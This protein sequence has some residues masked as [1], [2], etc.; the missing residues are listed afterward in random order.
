MFL[1]TVLDDDF[2]EGILDMRGYLK[3][4]RKEFRHKGHFGKPLKFARVYDKKDPRFHLTTEELGWF[5]PSAKNLPN[6]TYEGDFLGQGN[7]ADIKFLDDLLPTEY[8][9]RSYFDEDELPY[10]LNIDSPLQYPPIHF[11]CKLLFSTHYLIFVSRSELSSAKI[12]SWW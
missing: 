4:K 11:I 2:R 7:E 1:S 3:R 6:W 8:P 12:D 9:P 10:L 5:F